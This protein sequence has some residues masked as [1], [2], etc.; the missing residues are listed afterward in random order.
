MSHQMRAA[1]SAVDPKCTSSIKGRSAWV[2]RS[3]RR[4]S[5][6]MS[7]RTAEAGSSRGAIVRVTLAPVLQ[8]HRQ[9]QRKARGGTRR[10]ESSHPLAR[11]VDRIEGGVGS[12]RRCLERHVPTPLCRASLRYPDAPRVRA[13]AEGFG[14]RSRA[15]TGYPLRDRA[16]KHRAGGSPRPRRSRADPSP[17]STIR[18][19]CRARDGTDRRQGRR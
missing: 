8:A 16:K 4:G 7:A 18:A 1:S 6:L 15:A 3:R 17:R 19:M 12:Q 5:L 2:T 11:W 9:H 10:G 14:R 13:G